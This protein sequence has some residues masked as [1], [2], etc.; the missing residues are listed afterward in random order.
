MIKTATQYAI[1]LLEFI[2]CDIVLVLQSNDILI[3]VLA[4]GSKSDKLNTR[5]VLVISNQTG[6]LRKLSKM[7]GPAEVKKY[8][9]K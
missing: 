5:D 1:Y 9:Y 2:K 4:I 8:Q 7:F 6:N 3:L